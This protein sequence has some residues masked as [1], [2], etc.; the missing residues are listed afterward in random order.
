[1]K[2]DVV[3]LGEVVFDRATRGLFL[4]DGCPVDL[5]NKSK[6][7]LIYLLQRPNQTVAKSEIQSEI[8]TDVIASDESLVQCIADIRR[9]IGKDARKVIETVPREGYRANVQATPPHGPVTPW[10][11][12]AGAAAAAFAVVLWLWP[13]A[14]MPDKAPQQSMTLADATIRL[15]GT[16]NEAAYL[17]LLQGRVSA[18]RF[19]LDESLS[20]ERHFRQ[21]IAFDPNFARAHAEL[22]TLLAIRFENNWSILEEADKQKALYYA[23][24]AIDIDPELWLGHYAMGRLL[25]VFEDLDAAERH[26]EMAM[27]LKPEN[28]DARAYLGVVLNF[29]GKAEEA[30]AILDQAIASHPSPPHWYFFALGHSLFNQRD[31][32]SAL[33]A[34]DTCLDLTKNS[35]YCLRYQI[36]VYGELGEAAKAQAATRAYEAMGFQGSVSEIVSLM[37]FHHPDDLL[38]LETGLRLAGLPD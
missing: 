25:S 31:Y 14:L 33:D 2:S 4:K 18:N 15:P 37:S 24:R 32:H 21:A 35:P 22:G 36:A 7:V 12:G 20:A 30:T 28:E 38:Q 34:L 1:M 6:A 19:S 3:I 29:Q 16:D 23:K 10:L 5:R 11:V 8:W 13:G 17:E 27:S 9:I 26:L